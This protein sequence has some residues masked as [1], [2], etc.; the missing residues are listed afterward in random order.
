M[1]PP[2]RA[3]T[4][5]VTNLFASGSL[6]L[7][8]VARFVGHNDVTT[9]RGYPQH[10]G[11]RPRQVSKRAPELLD[12]KRRDDPTTRAEHLAACLGQFGDSVLS[13]RHRAPDCQNHAGAV[14]PEPAGGPRLLIGSRQQTTKALAKQYRY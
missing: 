13:R 2:R 11:D 3:N 6:D 9:T 10:D 7:E 1:E 14:R 12:P 4:S 5:I 8:D